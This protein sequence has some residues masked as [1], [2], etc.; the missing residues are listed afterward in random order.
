MNFLPTREQLAAYANEPVM[1]KEPGLFDKIVN[2]G[3]AIFEGLKFVPGG[4]VDTVQD[5]VFGFDPTDREE[6][7]QRAQTERELQEYRQKYEGKTFDGVTDAMASVPYSL[8][9][10]GAIR[11]LRQHQG[12]IQGR[13]CSSPHDHQSGDAD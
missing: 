8:T 11:P 4:A 6:M 2:S 7:A 5:A 1:E 3:Q 10:M 13:L 12:R 9:T